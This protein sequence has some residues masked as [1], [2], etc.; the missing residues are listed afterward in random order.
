MLAGMPG[1]RGAQAA[2]RGCCVLW[3]SPP[4]LGWVAITRLLGCGQHL[5]VLPP[6]G[7]GWQ[8]CR[9]PAVRTEPRPGFAH[10]CQ[11]LLLRGLPAG[12]AAPG[13]SHPE[14]YVGC[15]D[16]THQTGTAMGPMASPA[17]HPRP[18][19]PAQGPLGKEGNPCGV[20][21]GPSP[22]PGVTGDPGLQVF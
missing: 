1:R 15:K 8:T 22:N 12:A 7:L 9:S 18:P 19:R 2:A 11:T 4:C 21:A 5:S 20:V 10:S 16:G 13:T 14:P 17:P 3:L 6:L